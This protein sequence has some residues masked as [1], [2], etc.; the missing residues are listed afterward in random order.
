MSD[1]RP[2]RQ[3]L[4]DRELRRITLE[5]AV[6]CVVWVMATVLLAQPHFDLAEW[7]TYIV[8][9]GGALGIALSIGWWRII[10]HGPD[11]PPRRQRPPEAGSASVLL[12]SA[13]G[14]LVMCVLLLVDASDDDRALMWGAAFGVLGIVQYVRYVRR[15][16]R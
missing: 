8:A 5:I 14:A 1:E 15:R 12:F 2:D 3:P 11:G 10:R 4:N 9:F 6:G 16:D 13:C 7:A